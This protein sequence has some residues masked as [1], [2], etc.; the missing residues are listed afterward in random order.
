M[1][2][3]KMVRL[4][5]FL[6]VTILAA[7]VP[8]F[9]QV[10]YDGVILDRGN[11]WDG[12]PAHLYDNGRHKIWWCSQANGWVD[13]IYYSEKAGSL[14]PGG[15]STPQQ[16]LHQSQVPWAGVHVCDPSVIRSSFSEGGAS[17]SYALYFTSLSSASGGQNEIGVAFSNNGINWTPH[18]TPVVS[19]DPSGNPGAYGAGMSGV[20]INPAVGKLLFH[21]YLDT[22]YSP[23]LRL[24]IS[25]DGKNFFPSP[26]YATQL[27]AA[28][29]Q[30]IDGQGPDI[31]FNTSDN[32]WYA[33][34]KNH[35]Q[36]GIYDG[37]TRVLRATNAFDLLG[38]WEVIGIFNSTV[39]GYP[40]N[41]NPGLGKLPQGQLYIDGDGWA[42]VFFSVGL[43]PPSVTTWKVAQGRFRARHT[44]MIWIQPQPQAGFGPPGSLVVAGRAVGAP[45]GTRVTFHWRNLT[46]GGA[47]A[48]HAYRPEPNANGIWYSSIPD[49][50]YYD[51]YEVYATFA[52]ATSEPCTYQGGDII[53]W[54]P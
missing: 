27:H 17:Y 50:D 20:A 36:N 38:G 7:T 43:E 34:I 14:G 30:G 44:K 13:A 37:E 35:D 8:A 28:G 49:A 23:L 25:Y 31:A 11:R 5:V 32:H 24:N 2:V 15:W 48:T 33:T 6:H 19:P 47:W 39:T 53:S 45:S 22:S 52:G 12:Y 46:T 42:Y 40:Q 9:S 3:A 4:A 26:P 1:C 21:V 51:R 18:D 10:A 54:C 16:V 29:R 41:H